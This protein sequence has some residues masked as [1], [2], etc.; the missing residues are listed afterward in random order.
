MSFAV[1]KDAYE[2]LSDKK[3]RAQLDRELKAH[4]QKNVAVS[5]STKQ[6]L[7]KIAQALSSAVN[8]NDIVNALEQFI[9]DHEPQALAEKK[10]T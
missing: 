10:I 3:L 9:K 7:S 2:T 1:I 4:D 5:S 8:Q 6:A